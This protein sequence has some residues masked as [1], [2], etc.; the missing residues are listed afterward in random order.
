MTSPTLPTVIQGGMGAGISNWS[1]ARAVSQA[2]QL[3]VVAGTALDVI[4]VRRL[5]CGDPGGHMRRALSRFPYPEVAQ[6]IVQRY[7]IAGGKRE[8]ESFSTL[9]P[10]DE[11]A[12]AEREELIVAANFTEVHLAREGHAGAVGIN[13]LEKIQLPTLPSLFGAMLA[14]VDYVLM[15]AG[16]PRAIPAVLDGLAAG[17]PVGLSLDVRGAAADEPHTLTF[18]PRTF[19]SGAAPE[20]ERPAFLAI[21][22]SATVASVMARKASGRVDGLVIEG[23]A[24]GGHNAPPRGRLELTAEGE[25]VYGTRDHPDLGAIARL[26]LPFWLAGSCASPARLR[27]A[28]RAGAVGIQVG[29]AF[30]FCEESGLRLDLK[31]RALTKIRAGT[32][33][34]RTDPKA[35][36]T[37][38]PFKVFQL[39]DTLSDES[40][41]EQRTRVCDLG[42]LRHAYARSDGRVGW[43]CP[44]EST[45][46]FLKKD[47]EP[48]EVAGRKCVC[49]GL[50]ANIGLGQVRRGGAV[51]APLLTSGTDTALVAELSAAGP[52]GNY[53]ARNVLEH[54]LSEP[55]P[56]T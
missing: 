37:G 15:G 7:F 47:G 49:N 45:A 24:A 11:N 16:I 2:G 23:P 28:Q 13:Y 48:E 53:S 4:L 31:R 27:E 43:R 17:R 22:A 25:P 18:D 40:L 44:G 8:D 56:G 52:G 54:L 46:S 26:G 21:V 29:T 20:L 32:Q 14:G 34:V 35:S 6:R 9:P 12:S 51:E 3:G 39:E 10:L 36:P 55:V 30:A 5:Q 41:F 19:A 1:L 33:V 38:F 42:Y 50:L